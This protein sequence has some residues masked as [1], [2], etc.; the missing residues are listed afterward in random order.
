M[1]GRYLPRP[2]TLGDCDQ[3]RQTVGA[4]A[5]RAR[6]RGLTA[7]VAGHERLDDGTAEGLAAVQRDVREPERVAALT[8][9]QHGRGRAACALGIGRPL[10]D[11]QPQREADDVAAAARARAAARRRNPLR[12]TSRRRPAPAP[13]ASASVRSA[14]SPRAACSASSATAAHSR[15]RP[16]EPELGRRSRQA[17]R[18]RRRGTPRP[19][20]APARPGGS[21]RGV[22]A[23][24]RTEARGRDR[25]V[26]GRAR[27]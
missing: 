5:G 17:T 15:A 27:A 4:V 3:R 6:I 9:A 7:R 20:A 26:R 23:G 1:A 21:G 8:R 18:G 12:P 22:R 10:V 16:L 13:A 25:A 14:A 24:S 2:E 19:C 11:P